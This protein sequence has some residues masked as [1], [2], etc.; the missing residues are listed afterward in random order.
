M[1]VASEGSMGVSHILDDKGLN[2]ETAVRV[3]G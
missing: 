2:N 3:C 1:G